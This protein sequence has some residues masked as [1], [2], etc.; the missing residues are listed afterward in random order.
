M[1]EAL[2]KLF[3][4]RFASSTRRRS[5]ATAELCN[6]PPHDSRSFDENSL[7][8]APC[9]VL[10]NESLDF[11]LGLYLIQEL[12]PTMCER[13]SELT[14]E[15][16]RERLASLLEPVFEFDRT[17][18]QVMAALTCACRD[19]QVAFFREKRSTGTALEVKTPA[20]AGECGSRRARSRDAFG[21][22]RRCRTQ[23]I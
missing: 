23:A 9:Y 16:L 12:T 17:A 14:L 18:D 3:L 6:E 11:A 5:R 8:P 21:V 10:R 4:F 7:A 20:A 15:H 1:S 22:L 13:G 2:C 19:G